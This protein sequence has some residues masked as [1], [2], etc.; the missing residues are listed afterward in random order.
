MILDC[1]LHYYSKT[2][3]KDVTDK[4]LLFFYFLTFYSS[5]TKVKPQERQ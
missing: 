3:A 4:G 2:K 5:K 1:Y